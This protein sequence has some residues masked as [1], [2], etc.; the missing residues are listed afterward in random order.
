MI[1]KLLDLEER[2]ILRDIEGS[3][4]HEDEIR[5]ADLF[6]RYDVKTRRSFYQTR[7]EFREL[8]NRKTSR[9]PTKSG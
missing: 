3:E 7:R 9:S 1:V 2:N 5:R 8:K 4:T 6:M